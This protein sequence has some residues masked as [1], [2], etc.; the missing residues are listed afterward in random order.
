MTL[1][2]EWA[3][4]DELPTVSPKPC[5]LVSEED[6]INMRFHVARVEKPCFASNFI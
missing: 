3:E 1:G 5:E 6:E 2:V 4:A